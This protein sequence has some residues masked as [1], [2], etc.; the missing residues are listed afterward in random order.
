[1]GKGGGQTYRKTL[2]K[3][4][5]RRAQF[6][7][8]AITGG[9]RNGDSVLGNWLSFYLILINCKCWDELGEE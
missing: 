5:V 2:E 7:K 9:Q 1:M 8:V 3:G 6:I 4:L